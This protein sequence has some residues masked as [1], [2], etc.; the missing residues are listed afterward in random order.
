[1]ENCK[2]NWSLVAVLPITVALFGYKF[3]VG[4][5]AHLRIMYRFVEMTQ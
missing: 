2:S 4:E 3:T 5:S 1:M